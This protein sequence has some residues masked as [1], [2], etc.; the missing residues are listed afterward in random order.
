MGQAAASPDMQKQFAAAFQKARFAFRLDTPFQ[1]FETNATRREGHTLY[2]EI[3]ASDAN[4]KLPQTM[5][6]RFKK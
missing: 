5:M 4:P 6:A 1:V 2:W 3:K